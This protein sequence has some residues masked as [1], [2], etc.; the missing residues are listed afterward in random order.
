MF[1]VCTTDDTAHI[2]KFLP[3]MHQHVNA[4]VPTTWISYWCVLCHPWCIHWTSLVVKKKLFQFSCGCEK[5]HYG[6]SFGFLIINVCNHGEHYETPCIK[7][8]HEFDRTHH[9]SPGHHSQWQWTLL[10]TVQVNCILLCN[11]VGRQTGSLI[12][13][14]N[15]W[16]IVSHPIQHNTQT[17]SL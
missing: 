8:I 12:K 6:R 3:H 5:F 11:F 14:W 9:F 1:N 17:Y 7:K 4:C 2:F 10:N 15:F 16:Y 13:V